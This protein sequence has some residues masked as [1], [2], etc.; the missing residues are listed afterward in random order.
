MVLFVPRVIKSGAQEKLISLA[1]DT[2][3]LGYAPSKGLKWK[4]KSAITRR[5]LQHKSVLLRQ[6]NIKS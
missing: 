4:G 1:I 2:G 6:K 3:D 5:Q